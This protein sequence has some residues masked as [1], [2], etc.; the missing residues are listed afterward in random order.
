MFYS[1][2]KSDASLILQILRDHEQKCLDLC[3]EQGYDP[4]SIPYVT[5][6]FGIIYDL[7]DFLK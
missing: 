6:L 4:S 1:L 2:S 7:E 5:H 3:C